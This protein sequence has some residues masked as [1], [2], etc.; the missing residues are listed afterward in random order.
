MCRVA[1]AIP[2]SRLYAGVAVLRRLLVTLAVIGVSVPVALAL[3]WAVEGDIASAQEKKNCPAG[4][5]WERYPSPIGCVQTKL[6]AH[7][8]IGFD[9]YAICEDG[10]V[11]DSE[12]R[13][14]TEVNPPQAPLTRASPISTDATRRKSM[15]SS[16]R[17]GSCHRRRA[18]GRADLLA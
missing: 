9:G 14:T 18:V 17:R 16:R 10:Y 7:G 13:P 15:L 11:G 12:Q 5:H 4:F 8:K 6:P 2:G 1:L 3:I